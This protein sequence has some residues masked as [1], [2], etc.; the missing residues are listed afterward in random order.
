MLNGLKKSLFVVVLCSIT[1]S[2]LLLFPGFDCRS[3]TVSGQ[4]VI[5]KQRFDDA[6]AV[7][8]KKNTLLIGLYP[9]FRKSLESHFNECKKLKFYLRSFHH[10]HVVIVEKEPWITFLVNHKTVVVSEDG[11]ILSRDAV[12][13]AE[14]ST[15]M[16]VVRG[17]S[18][19]YFEG[20]YLD[21]VIMASLK[22]ITE[23]INVYFPD[24]DLQLEYNKQVYWTLL[25]NDT[26]PIYIGRE[27]FLDSKFT[28]LEK[29]F[30]DAR[31][32]ER[33]IK[34]IDSRVNNRVLVTYGTK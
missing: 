34:A 2:I 33:P 9:S 24:K 27:E 18:P 12:L 3:I 5:T 15:E 20:D 29:F 21:P 17:L 19:E 22:Q 32:K 23:K 4:S 25:L 13:S 1:V 6:A 8:L 10:L 28:T 16:L 26:I 14:K 11:S 30:N 31:S 7:L